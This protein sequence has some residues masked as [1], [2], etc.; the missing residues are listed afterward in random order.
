MTALI[1]I[2]S[3]LSIALFF[4]LGYYLWSVARNKY[5]YNIFNLGVI[6]RGLLALGCLFMGLYSLD[7]LDGS[8]YVW[9]IAAGV[10]W[11]WNFITTMSKT[12]FWIAFF[13]LFYQLI[14]IFFIKAAIEKVSDVVNK[15]LPSR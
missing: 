8:D 11:L 5:G 1:I 15:F 2:G 6:V 3:I 9:F 13:S 14:A 7:S 10:L 12:N 4:Y